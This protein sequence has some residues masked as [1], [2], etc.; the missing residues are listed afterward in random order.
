MEEILPIPGLVEF[1]EL[2]AAIAT[3]ETLCFAEAQI[4]Q[5]KLSSHT[6]EDSFLN[7]HGGSN[8]KKSPGYSKFRV[9]KINGIGSDFC[10][11]GL[12]VEV[13]LNKGCSDIRQEHQSAPSVTDT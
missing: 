3:I 10:Q 2:A 9:F 1:H 5:G 8:K 13:N 12:P 11:Q 7:P 4:R 6:V